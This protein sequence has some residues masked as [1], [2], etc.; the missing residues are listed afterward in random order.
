MRHV[1]SLAATTAAAFFILAGCNAESAGHSGY[2]VVSCS[3]ASTCRTGEVCAHD[4]C[5][6]ACAADS[7]CEH[8]FHVFGDADFLRLRRGPGDGCPGAEPRSGIGCGTSATDCQ[9][10][11]KRGRRPHQCDG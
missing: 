6:S 5:L 2:S 8:A 10:P 7:D 11:A 3:D 1:T 9:L 4:L